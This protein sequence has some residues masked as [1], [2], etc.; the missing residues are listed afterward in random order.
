M[1]ASDRRRL[2]ARE[3]ARPVAGLLVHFDGHRVAGF[4]GTSARYGAAV[5]VAAD[6]VGG[7][8]LQGVVGGGHADAGF[9]LVDAVDPEVLEGSVEWSR[10]GR[11]DG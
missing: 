9:A 5:D 4:D 6:V 2:Q 3:S 7:D 8:V 1:G 10:G 11:R